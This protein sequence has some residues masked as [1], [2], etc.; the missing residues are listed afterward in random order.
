MTI[1]SQAVCIT[2]CA[3]AVKIASTTRKSGGNMKKQPI[4][5]CQIQQAIEEN[6]IALEAN[7][8][9]L[10]LALTETLKV[11]DGDIPVYQLVNDLGCFRQV[12]LNNLS[13]L[14]KIWANVS[15]NCPL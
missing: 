8:P 11:L 10:R 5:L 3:Q 6:H 13:L 2:H 12:L 9:D 15:E 1:V 7:R 14:Q 4:S